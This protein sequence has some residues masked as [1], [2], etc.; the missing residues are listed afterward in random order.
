MVLKYMLLNKELFIK[1]WH[2]R[3]YSYSSGTKFNK[4]AEELSTW[5]DKH[6]KLWDKR[7]ESSD[8]VSTHTHTDVFGCMRMLQL[9]H[10]RALTHTLG[11]GTH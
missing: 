3:V 7:G 11:G 4:A 1:S 2:N 8:D 5:F 9:T 10:M 6:E